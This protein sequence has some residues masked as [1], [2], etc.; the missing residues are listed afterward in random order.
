MWWDENQHQFVEQFVKATKD[1]LNAADV[2]YYVFELEKAPH[3]GRVHIQGYLETKVK[4]TMKALKAWL[5]G[6][7]LEPAQGTQPENHTYCTKD[8]TGKWDDG[9]PVWGFYQENGTPMKQGKRTDLEEVKQ[10]LDDG[11]TLADVADQDFGAYVRYHKSLQAYQ[12]LAQGRTGHGKPTVIVRT[13]PTGTGKTRYVFDNHDLADIW[14]W[15][16][17]A[18]FDGYNGQSVVLFDDVDWG[19]IPPYRYMLQLLDRYPMQVPIKGGFT[20]W[21]PKT[22]YI[23]SNVKPSCWWNI[24]Q[25][26]DL[27]PFLRRLT[28][29]VDVLPGGVEEE[30]IIEDVWSNSNAN[31]SQMDIESRAEGQE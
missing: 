18:W 25:A 26:E 9:L 23:T 19:E 5:E 30:H 21:R 15:P 22:I 2:S 1:K 12:N 28:K 3:T 11:G 16:R 7:H 31:D 20:A 13:G 27:E 24:R 8:S 17:G 29:V 4:R 6:A 14:V 10:I